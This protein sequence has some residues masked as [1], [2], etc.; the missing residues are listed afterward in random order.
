M[1]ENRCK[2]QQCSHHPVEYRT[3]CFVQPQWGLTGNT[4][5]NKHIKIF[6]DVF[7]SI[8][9]VITSVFVLQVFHSLGETVHRI[10]VYTSA[11]SPVYSVSINNSET[12][13]WSRLSLNDC[14]RGQTG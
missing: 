13:N 8:H 6:K 10:S 1:E 9:S 4:K 11:Q 14:F 7:D 12:S 2:F 5:S 3:P